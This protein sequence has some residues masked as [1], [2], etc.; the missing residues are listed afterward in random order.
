MLTIRGAYILTPEPF[1]TRGTILIRGDRIEALHADAT[2]PIPDG[3]TVI[4]AEGLTAVPGLIDLQFN[5][6]FGL[7]FTADPATIWDVAAQLPQHGVTAFLPTIIT[8]PLE[9]SRRAQEVLAAGPPPGFAGARP[10][11]LHIEGPFLNP[12]KKGA[13]NPAHLRLPTPEAV[14]DWS[15]ET[16]VRLVTLAPEL[17]GAL[18]VIPRLAGRG[19]L[20]SAG[21]SLATYDEAR[22][23]FDAGIRYATHLFNA[24]PTLH[25]RQPGLAAAAL[26][27]ERITVGLLADGLHIHPAL[28][29]LVWRLTGPE[30]FSLVTDAMAA[31]GMP[32]GDYLLGDYAVTVDDGEARL[33]DRTLAGCIVSMD[34]AV[35]S[36]IAYSGA[37]WSE[38]LATVTTT[39][40]RL[41]GLAGQFGALVEGA[42]ADVVLLGPNGEVRQT[43]IGG[44]P[45][46]AA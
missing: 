30:R 39:P 25:H 46:Y 35:R 6:G 45:V 11:G 1:A 23:G 42:A 32:P 14:A 43:L 34:A 5:G 10:L 20:V 36:L 29:D 38:A 27:D 28:V 26:T 16:G 18:D 44:R 41:L 17:P 4:D 7:D 2:A 33:A 13:H 37:T 8:A 21:H 31:L 9:V 40:A 24:M 12:G 3:T 19:V 22:A 15:P